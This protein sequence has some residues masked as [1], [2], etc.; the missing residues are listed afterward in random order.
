M[1]GSYF[2]RQMNEINSSRELQLYGACL[3]LLHLAGT[4]WWIQTGAIHFL[5][6]RSR[7]LCWPV[8]ENCYAFSFMHASLAW[9]VFG[10]YGALAL[11]SAGLFFQKRVKPAYLVFVALLI[12]KF[13]LFVLDFRMRGNQHYFAF[14]IFFLYV[15]VPEKKIPL[16]I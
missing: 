10:A 4:I 3:S 11:I 13:F 14:I 12:F 5:T 8:F 2:R 9:A 15:L 1:I 16:R 6:D 7:A